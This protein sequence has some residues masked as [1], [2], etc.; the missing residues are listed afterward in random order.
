MAK[1]I[2]STI[3][4]ISEKKLKEIVVSEIATCLRAS[5]Y[6]IIYGKHA[7]EKMVY[8]L[9]FHNFFANQ[10]VYTIE[11]MYG[12]KCEVE[13]EVEYMGVKGRIDVYCGDFIVEL[14]FTNTVGRENTFYQHYVRQLMYYIAM[15]GVSKGYLVMLSFEM[16]KYFVDEL[17]LPN[18]N[19]EQ[20]LNEIVER[21][22]TLLKSKLMQI[23]P[24]QEK[25]PWCGFCRYKTACFNSKLI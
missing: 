18:N 6:S 8:G 7:T 16:D 12:V 24:P 1:A 5:Y 15:S 25:G 10:L 23:E 21:A 17:Y 13:K 14:K 19:R 9:D 11:Q 3:S 4:R 20:I 2:R 22:S